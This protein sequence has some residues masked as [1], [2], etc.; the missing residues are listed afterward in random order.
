MDHKASN[1][2]MLLSVVIYIDH[3]ASIIMMLLSVVIYMDLKADG[4][5]DAVC[6]CV[7]IYVV[8]HGQTRGP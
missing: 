5:N 3:K 2:M 8:V 7:V 1:I 4:Y 6:D